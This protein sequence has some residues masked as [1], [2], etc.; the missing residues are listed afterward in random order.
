[1][2]PAQARQRAQALR[3]RAAADVLEA[4]ALEAYAAAVERARLSTA[5][6]PANVDGMV[7]THRL[8][9]SARRGAPSGL[10]EAARAR[11]YTLRELAGRV[12]VSVS[13]L[14]LVA[15]GKRA[16]TDALRVALRREIGWP[17]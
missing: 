4:E 11:G 6:A 12:G 16:L 10:A 17:E 13:L 15:R 7:S 8:A 2:T 3:K 1:M 5:A 14:S 9:I